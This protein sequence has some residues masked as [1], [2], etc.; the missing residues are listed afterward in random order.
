MYTAPLAQYDFLYTEVLG[1][2]ILET[3]TNG[4]I[5]A[6]DAAAVLTSAADFAA[7]M[8]RP[9]N[10][11]GDRAGSVLSD[12]AVTTPVGYKQAYRSFA[13]AGWVGFGLDPSIDGGGAPFL[14]YNAVSELWSAANPAFSVCW[15]LSTG[16]AAA[17]H[18]AASPELK[19]V[20]LAKVVSGQWTGTM[21]LTESDA[22]TDLSAIRTIARPNVD[23]TW[24]VTGQK[25][26][27]T[28]GDH[29]LT[30]NIVHLVLART[31]DA[32][33]GLAGLSLFVVPKFLPDGR[34]GI[35]EPNRVT[36]LSLEH[37]LGLHSSP[38][39]V[40]DYADATGYLVGDLHR[41]LSAMFVMMNTARIGIGLQG[42]G[43]A[44]LAYQQARDYAQ[45]RVQGTVVGRPSGTPIA[46]HPDVARLLTSM[47]SSISAMRAFSMQVAEWFDR[48]QRTDSPDAAE[49]AEFCVPILKAWF[50]E[51]AVRIASDG[52]QV[53]GGLGFIE[54]AGAAQHYRDARIMPIYEGTT[55]I[56]SN[57]LLGRKLIR[58]GGVTA[59][60]LFDQIDSSV[61]S[62][63]VIEHPVAA[64]TAERLGRALQTVRDATETL[65]SHAARN[66]RDAY[67]ASVD[68]LTMLSL[69]VGAWMHGRIVAAALAHP[70][71]ST[72]DQQRLTEADFYG[73]HHLSRVQSLAEAIRAGEIG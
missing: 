11:V 54:E 36:T 66:P 62:L 40:L 57:D 21:N 7:E 1:T 31:P 20:Y 6:A 39:C 23:G 8:L 29:D 37:K 2:D 15:L 65:L 24:A 50:T 18:S 51:E 49:L 19:D 28:W 60:R 16:A 71:L 72:A 27:I 41:G 43:L 58:D 48:W 33:M 32:P 3:V 73:A 64:R 68:Y 38:T 12:G 5:K 69:L 61:G 70:E 47:S 9:L 26:F 17:L 44:D 53:Y 35:G 42:L 52:V 46:E 59:R 4:E 22:G 67:A 13:E 30:E 34:G 14:L 45:Q 25:I 63:R 56:Q 55:A 10:T